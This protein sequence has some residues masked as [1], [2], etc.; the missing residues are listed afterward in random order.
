MRILYLDL[1]TL[2]A[3]ET[4]LTAWNGTLLVPSHDRWLIKH[5]T[6]H[7]LGLRPART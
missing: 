3:L 5:W 1:D 2:E 7:R 4:A 6:G